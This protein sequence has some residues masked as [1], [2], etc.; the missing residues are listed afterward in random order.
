VRSISKGLVAF[1]SLALLTS[2]APIPLTPDQNLFYKRDMIVNVDGYVGEGVLVVP[3]KTEEVF[4]FDVTLKGKADLFTFESCHREMVWEQ[5]GKRGF[6]DSRVRVQFDYD[7]LN[8]L[9]TRSSCVVRLGGYDKTGRHSW[10]MVDFE[11]DDATLPAIVK[12]NGAHYHSRGVTVCQAK[13]GLIQEISFPEEVAY[14][15]DPNCPLNLTRDS[16][17]D[18]KTFRFPLVRGECVY[19]F[20]EKNSKRRIHRLTTLGY[21]QVLIRGN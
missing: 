17:R 3:K 20:I 5:A 21:D 1:A 7:P 11:G 4:K 12:C 18:G 10:A 2:C 14:S 19:A 15:P 8:G 6:F 13:V 16:A 9:E